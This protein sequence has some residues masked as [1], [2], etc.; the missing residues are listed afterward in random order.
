MRLISALHRHEFPATAR[1]K[2]TE[3]SVSLVRAV[4]TNVLL[5]KKFSANSKMQILP[6]AKTATRILA[7]R[8]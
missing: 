1:I 6:N 2:D 3:V 4:T 8:T 7:M 5:I